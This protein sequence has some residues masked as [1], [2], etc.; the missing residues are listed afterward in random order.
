M[1]TPAANAK[2]DQQTMLS[3]TAITSDAPPPPQNPY[4]YVVASSDAVTQRKN[5]GYKS[6]HASQAQ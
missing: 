4:S 6:I 5:P 3:T 1:P 2:S